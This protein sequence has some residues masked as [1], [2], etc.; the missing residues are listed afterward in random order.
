MEIRMRHRHAIPAMLLA[1]AVAACSGGGATPAP[2]ASACTPIDLKDAS[3]APLDLTGEWSAN[4]SGRYRLKQIDSCLTWVGL[5]HFDGQ[6]LG[7]SWVTT[8]RGQIGADMTIGGDFLDVSGTNP[9]SGTLRLKIETSP[10]ALGGIV[11]TQ[12]AHTGS[13]YGGSFWER[14]RPAVATPSPSGG[15]PSTGPTSPAG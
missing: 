6:D 8:F 7:D 1:A 10:D 14:V 11:L 2:A 15:R 3:G 13:P 12:S 9:G 4:D 5:S